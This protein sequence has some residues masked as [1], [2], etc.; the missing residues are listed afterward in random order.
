MKW[1]VR[2]D[3]PNYS[4]SQRNRDKEVYGKRSVKRINKL[5]NK[6]NSVSTARS[7]EKTRRDKVR[8]K[9]KYVRQGGKI[10]GGVAGAV[11]G[12]TLYSVAS[13]AMKSP[14]AKALTKKWLGDFGSETLDMA[15]NNPVVMAAV[16]GGTAK[17]GTMFSGDLAVSAYERA[18]GYNPNRR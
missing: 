4:K 14:K 5:M 16:A 7:S 15:M 6:G 13:K 2:K 3:N 8:S 11:T 18:H 12:F 9:S 1:G 17:V 10:A